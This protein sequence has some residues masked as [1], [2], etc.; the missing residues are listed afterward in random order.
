MSQMHMADTHF[1]YI[2]LLNG[3]RVQYTVIHTF[4]GQSNGNQTPTTK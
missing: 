1:I 2:Y 4:E 3:T